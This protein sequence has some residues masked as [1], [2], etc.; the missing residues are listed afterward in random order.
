MNCQIVK[1]C[2]T[3][4]RLGANGVGWQAKPVMLHRRLHTWVLESICISGSSVSCPRDT[5]TCFETI[6][7]SAAVRTY[8]T[9][10]AEFGMTADNCA[11]PVRVCNH[12]N[13]RIG[14]NGLA[15]HASLPCIMHFQ[16]HG[17]R[18]TSAGGW[19]TECD[20]LQRAKL[21]TQLN[22]HIWGEQ[23]HGRHFGPRLSV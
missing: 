14:S 5:D 15:G 20:G 7:G 9:T 2:D 10:P 11:S 1:T 23:R 21:W 3:A 22:G 6:A 17:S 12:L 19:S 16:N 8:P 4:F 13:L 18:R